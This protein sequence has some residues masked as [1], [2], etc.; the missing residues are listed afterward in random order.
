MKTESKNENSQFRGY[1]N[2]ASATQYF[3]FEIDQKLIL[4]GTNSF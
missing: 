4:P 1:E 2:S 3:N